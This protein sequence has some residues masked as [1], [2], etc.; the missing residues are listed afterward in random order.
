MR[1]I[2]T[3]LITTVLSVAMTVTPVLA[4][5]SIAIHSATEE[6][7][8]GTVSEPDIPET[9][10]ENNNLLVPDSADIQ[11]GEDVSEAETEDDTSEDTGISENV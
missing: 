1:K 4:T 6:V 7:P 10:L 5:E 11:P 3:W 9:T 2:G 8:V